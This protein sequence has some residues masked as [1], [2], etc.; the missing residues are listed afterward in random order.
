MA[1]AMQQAAVQREVHDHNGWFV[2]YHPLYLGGR[3]V[4]THE[5]RISPT[6]GIPLVWFAAATRGEVVKQIDEWEAS[7]A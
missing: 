1:I 3:W 4:A 6:S 5:K 7:R 2:V